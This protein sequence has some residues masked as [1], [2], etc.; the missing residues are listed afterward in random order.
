M[1]EVKNHIVGGSEALPLDS[2]K[3]IRDVSPW[4]FAIGIIKSREPGHSKLYIELTVPQRL[5]VS[6]ITAGISGCK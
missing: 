6:Q 3:S 2:E 1:V 5:L 4:N